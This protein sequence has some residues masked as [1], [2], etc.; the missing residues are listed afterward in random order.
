MLLQKRQRRNHHRL[1]LPLGLAALSVSSVCC[2]LRLRLA[3][4]FGKFAP[5]FFG[6]LV[7]PT[8]GMPTVQVARGRYSLFR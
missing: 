5:D 4:V 2:D 8:S 3:V 6:S 7:S 1:P